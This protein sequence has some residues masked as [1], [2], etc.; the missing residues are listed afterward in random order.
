MD[1]LA[2]I[3]WHIP[4]TAQAATER[5]AVAL[6][7][8]SP[9]GSPLA[10]S[11]IWDLHREAEVAFVMRGDG[12][13]RAIPMAEGR[14]RISEL[15]YLG[16]TPQRNAILESGVPLP[17]DGM[18]PSEF[19]QVLLR[20]AAEIEHALMV[21]YLY[22]AYAISDESGD[23]IENYRA[24][25]MRVAIQE[26]GHLATVQNLLVLLGGPT[27]THL[28]RDDARID[29]GLT[30]IPFEL[31]PVSQTTLALYLVAEMP[32][33]IPTQL[34]QEFAPILAK[35]TAATN[36]M[37]RRVGAIYSV[38]EWLFL[39]DSVAKS[40]IDL[41][42]LA[43]YP[44]N[45]HVT[46]AD[47]VPADVMVAHEA[48]R[49]EWEAH[50]SEFILE[51]PHD[52]MSAAAAVAAISEQGE[53]WDDAQDSHF[54]EFLEL[55]RDFNDGKLDSL[56]RPV[57]VSPTLWSEGPYRKPSVIEDPYTKLWG[58]VFSRQYTLLVLSIG[59]IIALGRNSPDTESLRQ[60]LASQTMR[61]M[62]R[63]IGALCEE[64]ANLPID[65]TQGNNCGANFDL[66]A[67]DVRSASLDDYADRQVS[68]LAELESEYQSIE[69]H[70]S[71]AG[72]SRHRILLSNLRRGDS[73]RKELF[74]TN[75]NEQ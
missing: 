37:L 55:Y 33:T 41:E 70:A 32:A 5:R 39:P 29:T 58:E 71:F 34:V 6:R 30:P 47:V 59:H 27:S 26:M 57:A 25:I 67:D 46:D 23:G 43:G 8:A 53:G 4:T 49:D 51:A 24:K 63:G 69:A 36:G 16:P 64:L 31:E 19:A 66:R 68:L 62:R 73:K 61:L 50:E 2:R 38:L 42:L 13:T 12:L 28:L 72:N 9:D 45:Y 35:A 52:C 7:R 1:E 56:L 10:D 75:E 54:V 40:W 18:P 65:A 44:E 3:G 14:H 11:P 22:A 74:T 20:S 60:R 48:T 17:I 15:R 21:Q